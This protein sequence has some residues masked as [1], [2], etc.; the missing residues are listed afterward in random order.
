MTTWGELKKLDDILDKKGVV[1]AVLNIE[2][3][4]DKVRVMLLNSDRKP[5]VVQ[6]KSDPVTLAGAGN[7]EN[8][9]E[10]EVAEPEP[11]LSEE[12]QR[13]QDVFGEDK[14]DLVASETTEEEIARNAATNAVPLLLPELSGGL[15][16]RSHLYLVHGLYVA[17]VD[18]NL[19]LTEHHRKSHQ[20]GPVEHPHQ[21]LSEGTA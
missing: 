16:L 18:S 2:P 14:V 21:H 3:V 19:A 17:D 9:V 6:A 13:V 8:A 4:G 12:L 11:E 15:E 5:I 20:D 10:T 1:W 7:F